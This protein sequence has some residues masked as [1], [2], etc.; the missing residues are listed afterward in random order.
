MS[1]QAKVKMKEMF[2]GT[3]TLSTLL[4]AGL[5]FYIRRLSLQPQA[6]GAGRP[7]LKS[8]GDYTRKVDRI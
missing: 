5:I 1:A 8:C 6:K 3:L 7:Q 4:L 2:L